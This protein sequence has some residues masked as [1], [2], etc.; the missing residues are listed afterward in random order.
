[1][2]PNKSRHTKEKRTLS[3]LHNRDKGK[4]PARQTNSVGAPKS[5]TQ[6]QAARR[7]I[8]AYKAVESYEGPVEQEARVVKNKDGIYVLAP[9]TPDE[10]LEQALIFLSDEGPENCMD[11]EKKLDILDNEMLKKYPQDKSIQYDDKM[12]Q[13]FILMMKVHRD[14][15]AAKKG[16]WFEYTMFPDY[17]PDHPFIEK[18]RKT[19]KEPSVQP[20]LPDY[21]GFQSFEQNI[22]AGAVTEP[23]VAT[24]MAETAKDTW[25][26]EM[27]RPEVW[28]RDM[29]PVFPFGETPYM[30]AELSEQIQSDLQQG[31][32][33]APSSWIKNTFNGMVE[34]FTGKPEG[35]QAPWPSPWVLPEVPE[36]K[37]QTAVK[38]WKASERL[39]RKAPTSLARNG[40]RR[41][42]FG[43]QTMS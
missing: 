18:K 11:F 28:H 14:Q 36:D 39:K 25:Y 10:R 13:R 42:M 26:E 22:Q 33:P 5:I 34:F 24:N 43:S 40:P 9:A 20:P 29:P 23:S 16:E 17:Y 15:I 30:E 3:Q 32:Q 12:F 41:P 2:A 6:V 7:K 38:Q 19:P 4:E 31:K 35:W 21:Q 8:P 37:V 27:P 1:M